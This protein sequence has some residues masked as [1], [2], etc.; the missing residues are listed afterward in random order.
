M[1]KPT[2]S[3]GTQKIINRKHKEEIP[4]FEALYKAAKVLQNRKLEKQQKRKD[5]LEEKELSDAT[6]CPLLISKYQNQEQ[7]QNKM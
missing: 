3:K 7:K 1:A 4:S 5:E 6:F 2:L